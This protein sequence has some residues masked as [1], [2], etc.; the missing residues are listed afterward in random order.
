M[1]KLNALLLTVCLS[2]PVLAGEVD[3]PGKTDP[4]PCTTNCPT[5]TTSTTVTIEEE[6]A[7]AL[8]KLMLTIT[9]P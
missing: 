8:L 3:T 6:L 2:A 9:G 5:N 4:P 7:L 1:R